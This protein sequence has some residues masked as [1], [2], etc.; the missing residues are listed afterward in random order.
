MASHL[1]ALPPEI[2][3][4]IADFCNQ[5]DGDVEHPLLHFRTSCRTVQH[6]TR[7]S[8]L[9]Q[10]FRSRTI[11]YDHAKLNKLIDVASIPEFTCNIKAID[12]ICAPGLGPAKAEGDNES[13]ATEGNANISSLQPALRDLKNIE[14][15]YVRPTARDSLLSTSASIQR[16]NVTETFSLAL[17]AMA[18][19]VLRPKVIGI[20]QY[21]WT[22]TMAFLSD[23][24]AL[25]EHAHCFDQLRRLEL[26]LGNADEEWSE[27]HDSKLI[28]EPLVQSLNDMQSLRCLFL[29]FHNQQESIAVINQLAKS[30][31]LPG[32]TSITIAC[33]TCVIGD[34]NNF[35][36]NHA[37]S[38]RHCGLDEIEAMEAHSETRYRNLL[39]A[40][41]DSLQL[42]SL[43]IGS[44]YDDEGD[45]FQF[46]AFSRAHSSLEPNT[47]GYVEVEH[48]DAV[49]TEGEE[50][51][52]S[53]LTQMLDC[54]QLV[55][56]Q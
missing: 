43:Y 14:E 39:E 9:R 54:M 51:V 7:R 55:E 29:V 44:L 25:L 50:N 28:A 8:W 18:A 15:V 23:C 27:D 49:V 45:S 11:R 37:E 4:I 21:Q 46:P 22:Q 42:D 41:R 3:E 47:D 26:G 10:Y 24:R 32:L 34:L 52:Q 19:C 2:L 1:E 6:A 40:L 5:D 53:V 12:F 30:A 48:C 36:R 17:S 20:T 13:S 31:S 35:M 33:A 38:L 16:V 56:G